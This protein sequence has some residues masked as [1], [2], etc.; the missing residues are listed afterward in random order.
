MQKYHR[1]TLKGEAHH[2]EHSKHY[3]QYVAY[4]ACIKYFD[5]TATT[6]I[7]LVVSPFFSIQMLKC[8]QFSV[9]FKSNEWKRENNNNVDLGAHFIKAIKIILSANK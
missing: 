3:S 5:L 1:D 2:L 4:G 8:T 7:K 6:E 9:Q